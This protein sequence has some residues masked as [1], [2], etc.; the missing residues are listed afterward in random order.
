MTYVTIMCSDNA[1]Y[2]YISYVIHELIEYIIPEIWWVSF[3]IYLTKAKYFKHVYDKLITSIKLWCTSHA[4]VIM[5]S[6]NFRTDQTYI[7]ISPLSQQVESINIITT[8]SRSCSNDYRI[9]LVSVA[10]YI[11][12]NKHLTRTV[13]TEREVFLTDTV[14]S[15]S[16]PNYTT[17]L[18]YTPSPP[19]RWFNY[20][21]ELAFIT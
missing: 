1:A 15:E 2:W 4:G 10:A 11:H 17:V 16:L 21:R 9:S 8:V 3:V 19:K 6:K 5:R 13:P 18:Q 14:Y 7:L 12:D 20:G